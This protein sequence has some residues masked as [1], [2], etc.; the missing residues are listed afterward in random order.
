MQDNF[1][2]YALI[3]YDI[4]LF[5]V[6]ASIR[7]R[8]YQRSVAEAIIDSVKN[9]KGLT[10]VVVFPRQSGKNELQAQIE[11]YL[12]TLYSISHGKMVKISPTIKPQSH[13]AIWRLE[14]ILSRNIFTHSRWIKKSGFVLQIGT[15]DNPFPHRLP[16]QLNRWC[17]RFPPPRM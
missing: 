6:V 7:L 4:S 5:T 8:S 15:S 10:F 13:T 12:L 1:S 9:R 16:H 2:K 17:D 11:A 14:Q 3:L